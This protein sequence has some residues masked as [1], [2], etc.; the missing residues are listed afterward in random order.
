MM[1]DG[2]YMAGGDPSIS[3]RADQLRRALIPFDEI[4]PVLNSPYLVKGWID[5]GTLSVVFGDPGAGKTFLAL[6]IAVHVAAGQRWHGVR[7]CDASPVVYIASEGGRGVQNRMDAIWRDNPDLARKAGSKLSLLPLI[8]DLC[9][10]GDAA[11][12]IRMMRSLPVLPGLIIVDTLARSMGAGDENA[13]PDMGAFIANLNRIQKDTGA[14]VM[15]IHHSG[16]DASRGARGHS[17]LKGATDT[18][19]ELTCEGATITAETKKQRDGAGGKVFSYTL[20]NVVLGEDQDGDEITSCVVEPAEAPVKRG[21]VIAGQAKVALQ[22]FGDALAHH[23]QKL[24]GDMFPQNRQCVSLEAWRD[25]CDR[26]DLSGGET[27]TAKRTA[28]HKSKV[29]LVDLGVIRVVDGYAW[30][31][32]E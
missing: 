11:A 18:E 26:H 5:R 30:R 20:R 10:K 3:D 2:P 19:I 7:V 14:H 17:S 16:K 32:T 22:A 31:V 12:V 29:K 13:G 23:G 8:L 6:D 25:Y 4:E 1:A 24:A 21:P 9:G 27:P 15:V 28:F